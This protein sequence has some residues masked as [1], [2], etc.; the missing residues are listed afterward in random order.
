MCA[1]TS[2]PGPSLFAD[3]LEQDRR[4]AA[5]AAAARS[6][7]AATTGTMA[8]AP[9]VCP[10]VRVDSS[11]LKQYYAVAESHLAARKAARAAATSSGAGRLSVISWWSC[12]RLRLRRRRCAAGPR[13]VR[14]LD[15]AMAALFAPHR[16]HC[17]F[18]LL[19]AFLY[20]YMARQKR[21]SDEA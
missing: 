19:P 11:A 20:M 5:A 16:R 14:P 12:K 17:L 9:S 18:Y 7:T 10:T 3:L 6:A 2:L 15:L 13:C 21:Y 4:A 8:A 1:G